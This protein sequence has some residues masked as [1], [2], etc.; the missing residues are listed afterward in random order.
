MYIPAWLIVI[1][2]VVGYLYFRSKRKDEGDFDDPKT[3]KGIWELAEFHKQRVLEKSPL[4]E[5][6][7]KDERD[8]VLA[9]EK[10]AI[11]LRER[12]KHQPEKQKQFAQ[13]WLDY[14]RAI[15]EIKTA[16]EIL[17]VDWEDGS[18]NRFDEDTKESFLVAQEVSKRIEQELGKDSHIKVVNDRLH[19]KAEVA[20]SILDSK[21]K[22]TDNQKSK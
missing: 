10:D 5:E 22:K 15:S 9:M 2:I 16:R 13:D 19:K 3:L 1:F 7:L 18:Y 6:Y 12:Y 20:N 4:I 14:A 17:D 21:P 8:L 11:R